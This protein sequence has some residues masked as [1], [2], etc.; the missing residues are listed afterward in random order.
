MREQDLLVQIKDYLKIRHIFY[1]RVHQSLGSN[2]G[3]SDIIAIHPS[4]GQLM[5][6]ELK[7]DKGKLTQEQDNFLKNVTDAS[8]IAAVIRSIE[9]L[10][11]VL[12]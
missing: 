12:K 4:S 9:D 7:G 10:E 3:I 2:R 8:G 5:A 1:F 11:A 6:L